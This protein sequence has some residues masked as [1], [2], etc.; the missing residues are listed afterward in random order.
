MIFGFQGKILDHCFNEKS[1]IVLVF[2]NTIK[3]DFFL[4]KICQFLSIIYQYFY[5]KQR[6][7]QF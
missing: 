2:S 6:Q 7:K 5:L 3:N 1:K 4:K